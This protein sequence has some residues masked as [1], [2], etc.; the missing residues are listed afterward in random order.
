MNSIIADKLRGSIAEADSILELINQ[1]GSL[2]SIP[3][4]V[5]IDSN[6]EIDLLYCST[7]QLVEDQVDG[8]FQEAQAIVDSIGG[9]EDDIA[10]G[11]RTRAQIEVP[12]SGFKV[13]MTRKLSSGKA[14]LYNV[15]RAEK[16]REELKGISHIDEDNSTIAIPCEKPRI[17]FIS[18]KSEDTNYAEALIS[19]INFIIGPEGKRVFCSS[20]QGYGIKQSHNIHD[21]LKRQFNDYE[22]FSI[23]I[24]SPRY[25][26]SSVC[27]NEMGAIWVLGDT[28]C[29]FYD[30]RL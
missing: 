16:T 13:G 6:S 19:L 11:F 5:S 1:S 10:K 20:V 8:W 30:N 2:L 22:V 24:H 7:R 4:P 17:V 23:I 18:H 15:L 25:Y 3:Y 21:T 27:L 28:V 9:K 29:I 12:E 26:N 14:Y